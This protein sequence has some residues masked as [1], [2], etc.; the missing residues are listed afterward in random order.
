[1]LLIKRMMLVSAAVRAL[2]AVLT[3]LMT[4]LC[5]IRYR[6]QQTLARGSPHAK[7]IGGTL[8]GDLGHEGG[9]GRCR[10]GGREHWDGFEDTGAERR[11]V[12][13]IYTL[14][15]FHSNI[16][17][18]QTSTKRRTGISRSCCRNFELN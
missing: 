5:R 11:Q 14:N 4:L 16:I 17:F 10:E 15:T 3:S 1:M 18:T 7:P 2:L 12:F 6:S 9:E 13:E 8:H